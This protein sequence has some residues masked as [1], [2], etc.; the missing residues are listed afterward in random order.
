MK[1]KIYRAF[2][3]IAFFVSLI[4]CCTIVTNPQSEIV[5]KF[6][7]VSFEVI[8][9]IL[10]LLML[11]RTGDKTSQKMNVRSWKMTVDENSTH[12]NWDKYICYITFCKKR[13]YLER[14][15]KPTKDITIPCLVG[16]ILFLFII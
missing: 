7:S 11:R 9:L 3:L 10:V 1:L 8:A 16:F 12:K 14:N 13:I 2:S 15:D 6:Y 5:I 4:M